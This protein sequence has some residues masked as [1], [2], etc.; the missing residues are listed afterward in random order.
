MRG[1]SKVLLVFVVIAV[2]LSFGVQQAKADALLFPYF[3]SGNGAYTFISLYNPFA[4][5]ASNTVNVIYYYYD[6]AAQ[7]CIHEDHTGTLTNFDLYQYEVTNQVDLDTLFGDA[8]AGNPLHLLVSPSEGF[9][10]VDIVNQPE[11][12]HGGQAA[13][14]DTVNGTV[15][16]YKALNNPFSTAP[17]TWDSVLTSKT[18]FDMTNYPSAYVNTS[19]F[20]LVTGTGM[21]TA[22][23]SWIGAVLLEN[24]NDRVWDRDEVPVSGDQP[25]PVICFDTIERA[26]IMTAGQVANSD[27]GGYWWESITAFANGA[28]GALMYKIESTTAF[29]NPLTAI[30]SENSWPNWPY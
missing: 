5:A 19:W 23:P 13:I 30:S 28:T 4:S 9:L 10:I 15:T 22:V 8:G 29:G 27:N 1:L 18:D 2:V 25:Y 12:N 16:T 26:D 6:P 24:G 14:I 17:G 11:G 21:D 20:V 3:K 7:A